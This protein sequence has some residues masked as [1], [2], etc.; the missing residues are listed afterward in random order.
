MLM[1]I[2]TLQ[3]DPKLL[4]EFEIPIETLPK[5]LNSTD[6][7]GV[8]LNGFLKGVPITGVIGDQ[9]SACLGHLLEQ[10]EVKNTYGTG[11][12][13]LMNTGN[14]IAFSEH[15]L[16]TTV[17][18][19]SSNDEE[20]LYALEGAIETAGSALN[21]LKN[22]LKLFTDFDMIPSLFKSV[23]DSGGVTFVP[24][25]SGLFSPHWDNS[26]RGLLIG[27][28]HHT[29]QGHI[30]R[31]TFE[32]ISLRTYEVIQSFEKES[33]INVK[34]LKVD[35]GMTSSDDFL[36]T[37]SNVLGILIEK[38]KEK[39][40]TIIGCAIAAGL[41]K[42]IST[43][44]WNNF[45]ELKNLIHVETL[46]ESKWSR[47]YFTELHSRWNKAVEKAKNWI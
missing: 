13:I 5:I 41:E 20:A 42:N 35:G 29:Q 3:W 39:E 47:E 38:Q 19:K 43:P 4:E 16:L 37:Q 45:S 18:Y 22:N 8:V 30:L 14:K 23:E 34:C 24:A 1:N 7:F 10:G 6:N 33:G 31:A 25:F 12:F 27:L 32:A 9:Q 11:C 21:W 44:I 28:S 15:G 17:L 46:F 26:A 2:K 36:Q 40:I